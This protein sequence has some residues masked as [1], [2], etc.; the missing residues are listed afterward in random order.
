M[1]REYARKTTLLCVIAALAAIYVV[2][3]VT[4]SRT[5]VRVVT[6]DADIDRITVTHAGEM[7]LDL[8]CEG[9]DDWSAGG[10]KALTNRANGLVNNIKAVTLLERVA[11]NADDAERYGLDDANALT[12][13]AYSAGEVVRTLRLGKVSAAG[14][15]CYVMLDGDGAVYLAQG[16]LRSTF[17][18]T[19]DT[20]RDRSADETDAAVPA[21]AGDAGE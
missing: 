1:K 14:G 11:R 4:D 3:R 8:V 6:C 9:E 12:A 20:I 19:A 16:A 2:Q 5:S 17:D 21:A 15:Q 7:Q 18:V 10:V 13:E